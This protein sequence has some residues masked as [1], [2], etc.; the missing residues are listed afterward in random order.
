MVKVIQQMHELKGQCRGAQCVECGW[1]AWQL[2]ERQ[3]G[4]DTV[5]SNNM[6]SKETMFTWDEQQGM[7]FNM[8]KQ[9]MSDK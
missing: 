7:A 1:I 4:I 2:H 8:L 3:W 5:P 6:L 9:A